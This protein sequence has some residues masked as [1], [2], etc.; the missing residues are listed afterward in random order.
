MRETPANAADGAQSK[1]ERPFTL[2]VRAEDTHD[3]AL[4]RRLGDF[5]RHSPKQK[6]NRGSWTARAVI[7]T[8][9]DS[10]GTRCISID[11]NM[12]AF[13]NDGKEVHFMR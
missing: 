7:L 8:P 5:K 11:R 9:P 3:L 13:V 12:A 10:I 6:Y 2:D 1:V 4:G